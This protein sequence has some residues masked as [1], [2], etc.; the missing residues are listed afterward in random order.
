MSL[1]L[2]PL[3]KPIL[4]R[5]SLNAQEMGNKK[6]AHRRTPAA[7]KCLASMD[8]PLAASEPSPPYPGRLRLNLEP[9][10]GNTQP[11]R[12]LKSRLPTAASR[13]RL[14]FGA[15]A[16]RE[17]PCIFRAVFAVLTALISCGYRK[18]KRRMM[19]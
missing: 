14:E 11:I 1:H 5:S 8:L 17:D 2:L 12:K 13:A 16:H 15:R 9:L 18:V 6:P 3:P 4:N 10:H 19:F 7:G